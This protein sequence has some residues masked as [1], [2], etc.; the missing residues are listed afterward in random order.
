MCQ[1]CLAVLLQQRHRLL[2]FGCFL[3]SL[4]L[5]STF[6]HE[7]MTKIQKSKLR[8][9]VRCF[10]ALSL[11]SSHSTMRHQ[12]RLRLCLWRSIILSG[13]DLP[14][15]LSFLITP[16]AWMNGWHITTPNCLY[17]HSYTVW[18]TDQFPN[19][20]TTTPHVSI[21]NEGLIIGDKTILW[22]PVLTTLWKRR[23]RTF[24]RKR[25][26]QVLSPPSKPL[27]GKY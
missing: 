15:V 1:L 21:T 24:S 17:H 12:K 14:L 4:E 27:R 8:L 5:G 25:D 16:F 19:L 23:R 18:S 6:T 9:C 3:A 7:I 13:R 11:S 10:V 26:Q 22:Y 2:N 20:Y